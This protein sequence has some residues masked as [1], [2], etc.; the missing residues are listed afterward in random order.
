MAD[1]SMENRDLWVSEHRGTRRDVQNGTDY[2]RVGPRSDVEDID[3]QCIHVHGFD[4]EGKADKV[5]TAVNAYDTNQATIKALVE[6][7]EDA[8][9]QIEYLHC[10]FDI[11]TGSGNAAI[12]IARA[13]LSL[14]KG[15][16]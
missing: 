1:H 12:S 2:Y 9:L 7:L 5:V 10:K 14:A 15:T 16:A 4:K 6:A 3:S 11:E 8:V 13:A